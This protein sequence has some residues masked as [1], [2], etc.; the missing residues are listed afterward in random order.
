MTVDDWTATSGLRNL[1]NP[2]DDL[3]IGRP[4]PQ[5]VTDSGALVRFSVECGLSL[6]V[7][8]CRS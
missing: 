4:K 8:Q 6:G 2:C 7:R 1:E 3:M 5:K